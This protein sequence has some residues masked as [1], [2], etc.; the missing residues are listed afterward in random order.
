MPSGSRFFPNSSLGSVA[1]AALAGPCAVHTLGRGRAT[2]TRSREL[3]RA[4][5]PCTK[6]L[7]FSGCNEVLCGPGAGPS[8]LERDLCA[9]ARFQGVSDPGNDDGVLTEHNAQE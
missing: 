7:D 2:K 1:E 4:P 8:G 9:S 3:R 5:F 6:P